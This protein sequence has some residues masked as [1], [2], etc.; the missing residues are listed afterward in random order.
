MVE[1]VVMVAVA[2][3]VVML[4]G[5]VVRGAVMEIL[6]VH[7]AVPSTNLVRAVS[8]EHVLPPGQLHFCRAP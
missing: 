3:T 2:V 4:M 1:S 5:I 6:R 8:L 7:L